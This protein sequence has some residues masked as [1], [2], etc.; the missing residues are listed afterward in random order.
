M[1][2]NRFKLLLDLYLIDKL[3]SP[4]IKE[5][6]AYIHKGNY[7]EATKERIKELLELEEGERKIPA[8]RASDLMANILTSE[9]K[10]RRSSLLVKRIRRSDGVFGPERPV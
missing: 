7:D 2:E 6:M 3:T 5:L 8:D 1:D 4:E 9:Q 10:Q